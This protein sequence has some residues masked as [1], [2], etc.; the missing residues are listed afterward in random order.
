MRLMMEETFSAWRALAKW[1]AL[2]FGELWPVHQWCFCARY[3][4]W[5]QV[6][7]LIY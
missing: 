3:G 4:A 6:S 1:R 7:R 2:V 5:F